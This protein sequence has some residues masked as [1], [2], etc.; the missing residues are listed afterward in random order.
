MK[1][2]NCLFRAVYWFLDDMDPEPHH[3]FMQAVEAAG[4]VQMNIADQ[5]YMAICASNDLLLGDVDEFMKTIN[6]E[7]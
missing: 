1:V 6:D 3:Q 4:V 2:P 7:Q 5:W